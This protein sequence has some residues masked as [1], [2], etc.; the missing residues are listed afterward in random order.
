MVRRSPDFMLRE[1][2]DATVL[3]PVGRAAAAFPGMISVNET[4][5]LIWEL[6]E[7][8]QSEENIAAWL[9]AWYEVEPG[10]ARADTQAFLRRLRLAGALCET[11]RRDTDTRT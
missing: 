10:Q 4:G 11:E 8:E 7:E 9:C 6:L 3:V 1:V 5:K 2:A